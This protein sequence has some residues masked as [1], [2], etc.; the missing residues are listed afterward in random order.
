MQI[1]QHVAEIGNKIFGRKWRIAIVYSL[2]D[3]AKRFSQ[4]KAQLPG[5]SVKVLSESL[6]DLEYHRIVIRKQYNTIPVKVTYELAGNVV[7]Y[8]HLV[9]AYLEFINFHLYLN[10][11]L[12][13]LPED[14]YEI[15]AAN[16]NGK[17][18]SK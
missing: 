18:E 5:C 13:N 17:K 9:I 1:D 12:Y 6:Q 8:T 16:H 15:I 11:D 3:G 2:R 10:N 14:V 4:V 7:P